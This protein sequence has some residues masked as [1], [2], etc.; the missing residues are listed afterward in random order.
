LLAAAIGSIALWLITIF[1]A[2]ASSAQVSIEE[3]VALALQNNP[4]LSAVA[5]ELTIAGAEII[6][7]DYF[8]QFNPF[9]DNAY[10]YRA[11]RGRS[12][13]NDWRGELTQELEV[14]GQKA[15]RRRSAGL[16]YQRTREDIRDE[17]RL[18]T[19]AVR[20]TFFETMLERDKVRLVERLEELDR[21]LNAAAQARLKAGKISEIESNLAQVRLGQTRR[22]LVEGRERYR[23]E[24]S[25]LGRL[26][27]GRAGPEPEPAGDYA[28]TLEPIDLDSLLSV[29]RAGRPDLRARQLEVARIQSESVLNRR[30]ALPNPTFGVFAAKE[31]NTNQLLGASLGF[32]IPIFNRRQ[33]EA[34][35]LAGQRAQAED[36]LL[37]AAL[38]VDQQV[39]DAYYR[40]LAARDGLEIYRAQVVAPARESFDLLN[41]AFAAGKIDLLLLSVALRQSFE[42]QM[43]YFDAYF[44]MLQAQAALELATGVPLE[45]KSGAV[46]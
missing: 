31:S 39:R 41:G 4:E 16:L 29:A 32:S 35:A 24:R 8:S 25:S 9:F 12:N 44:G 46:R 20:L 6:R 5:R 19:A 11:R 43:T 42:A 40:Y 22:D 15:A 14:F 13:S 17:R 38:D 45:S 10:N 37:G 18:L 7:A 26:L 27:A 1:P 33:A 3:A 23:I 28:T 34:T 2:G 36:R 21:S 30:L